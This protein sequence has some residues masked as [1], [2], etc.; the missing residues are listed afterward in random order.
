MLGWRWYRS[1]LPSK[2][3]GASCTRVNRRDYAWAES[4]DLGFELRK[5]SV[6]QPPGDS[7]RCTKAIMAA[8]LLD[9]I[10]RA[11]ANGELPAS[12]P[13][14]IA[15]IQFLSMIQGLGFQAADELAA[16]G[17]PNIRPL[18]SWRSPWPLSCR[19]ESNR[20]MRP[21]VRGSHVCRA[22]R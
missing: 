21:D 19:C 18:P 6:C 16:S 8:R 3:R 11:K 22:V 1:R 7:P 20:A 9:L 4:V 14:E 15:A 2:R 17:R 13:S 12:L 5:S 10:K